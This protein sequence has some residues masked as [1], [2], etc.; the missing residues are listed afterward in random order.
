MIALFALWSVM[1]WIGEVWSKLRP[2]RET[3]EGGLPPYLARTLRCFRATRQLH[4]MR[5]L[6]S[7]RP[8]ARPSL[9][10]NGSEGV[11]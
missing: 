4:P 9:R 10:S 3:G 11:V 7:F 6:A 5:I 8:A 2:G 1:A